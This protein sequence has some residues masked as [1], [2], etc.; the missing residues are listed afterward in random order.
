MLNNKMSLVCLAVSA[1][2]ASSAYAANKVDVSNLINTTAS[3]N[4]QNVISAEKGSE[5]RVSKEISLGKSGTK[6]R[7][8][9]YFYGIPVFGYSVSASKSNM[10][11]YSQV[12]GS[13]LANIAKPESFVKATITS[14][15]ALDIS[16]KQKSN[17]SIRSDA[18]NPKSDMWIYHDKSGEPRLVYI[19]S[20]VVYGTNPSRPFTIVDAKTGA[21][22]ERWEGLNHT[23][24]GTGP[25]GNDKVGQYEYGTDFG[26]LD[27]IESGDNCTMDS[28]N[29]ATVNLNHGSSGNTPFSYLCP[30]NTVK[31]INGAFSPLND[32]HFFGNVIYNMFSDW[33]NTA[34]LSFK[35]TM[36][37]HY[38]TEYENAFW[39][40]SAMT[41]GDGK[42]FFYPLVSLDV[43]AHEV[44][45]G[46]TEQNSGLVYAN[47][48]GGMNEAFSDMAGEAAEFYMLGS[49][50]WLVGAG[51]FKGEGALRYMADPTQDG[52]SIGNAADYY[53]GID[54]HHSSGVF[55]K[56]F[57]TLANTTGWD[58]RKAF[59]VMVRANQVY[60][61]AN[62]KFWDG[63][64]G[65]KSAAVDL[66]YSESDVLAAFT[67]VGV[68]AC[69]EPDPEPEPTPEILIN[70]TG[71][72]VS[73]NTGNKAYYTL[74]VGAQ[75]T[76]L[77]FA[78]TGGTGD[79]DLYVKF[80]EVPS[81][82]NYDCRPYE[83][84]N[85]ETC[86]ID[87]AQEGTY[88][89]MLHAWEA[90]DGVSLTGSYQ[91]VDLPNEAPVAAFEASFDR[92]NATFT[93]TSTDSDGDISDWSWNFGDGTSAN[94]EYATHSYTDSGS[95]DVSLTVTDDDG[96][97]TIVTQTYEVEVSDAAID[98]TVTRAKISNRGTIRVT[99]DWSGDF[100]Q[101]YT[102]YRDG[103]AVG[104]STNTHY[105]DRFHGEA[106]SSFTYK[107]CLSDTECSNDK[108]VNF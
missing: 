38:G 2:M 88:W 48:S 73:G 34:P 8:Q 33:Y 43:S 10:G 57:Y 4:I 71:V 93:S 40:G 77:S 89:V 80:G 29:V 20:Y 6:Q 41:F 55:N 17:K 81:S 21:V 72:Q 60:W 42:D 28:A 3:N 52:N 44:S 108:V 66:G 1:S 13:I 65:V 92:G 22:I 54:V 94:G 31:E 23:Q 7:L 27:V 79:A 82:D 67:A 83:S 107:V 49:N 61:T 37:V 99:L 63:A 96:A 30:R 74:E 19:T 36:R 45:H 98:L 76:D 11:L 90:F 9:Q 46:F 53:D 87:S 39:D 12:Q 24:L 95:Y 50:D 103:T 91:G 58:T 25:G 16:M 35:L 100:A 70:G 32:A 15:Q 51:I 56:A 14:E 106:G 59:D 64:C 47:R 62:S 26:F 78:I 105:T 85:E 86:S 97:S 69:V 84:G 104:T 101:S 102:V 75:P 68:E 18:N 5:F